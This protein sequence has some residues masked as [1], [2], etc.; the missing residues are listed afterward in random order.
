MKPDIDNLLFARK[1]ILLKHRAFSSEVEQL[2]LNQLVIGSTPIMPAFVFC[3]LSDYW[4]T[5]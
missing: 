3:F 5:H 2:T 4:Y 1:S